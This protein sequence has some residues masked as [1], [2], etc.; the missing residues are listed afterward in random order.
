[1]TLSPT[2]SDQK[3]PE[4]SPGASADADGSTPHRP[5]KILV[6]SYS[7]GGRT[8]SVARQL[9]EVLGADEEEIL[10]SGK[11]KG[12]LGLLRC[13]FEALA[14]IKPRIHGMR[15]DPRDYDIVVIGSPVWAAR[16]SSPVRSYLCRYASVMPR[17]ALFCTM[18]SSGAEQCLAEMGAL[19]DPH[20]EVIERDRFPGVALDDGDFW[21]ET[22][23]RRK[24]RKFAD[25]V[26]SI[27]VA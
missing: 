22:R 11:R 24:L 17:V 9:A 27:P 25:A 26:V 12:R 4:H 14:E 8:R 15:H 7:R 2:G 10:V 1:M 21:S 5:G 20:A 13:V 23:G 19:L 6:V 3:P 18:S 16:V